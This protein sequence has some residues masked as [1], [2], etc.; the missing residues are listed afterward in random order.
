MKIDHLFFTLHISVIKMWLNVNT[1]TDVE[2]CEENLVQV[3]QISGDKYVG[4][5]SPLKCVKK[6]WLTWQRICSLIPPLKPYYFHI[7]YNF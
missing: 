5:C 6:M 7:K 1:K 2:N 3:E 4:N